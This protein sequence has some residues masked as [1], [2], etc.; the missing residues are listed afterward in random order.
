ME[1]IMQPIK[2]G[3]YKELI[4]SKEPDPPTLPLKF[5]PQ[6]A[7]V[8]THTSNRTEAED[9]VYDFNDGKPSV[10]LVKIKDSSSRTGIFG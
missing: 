5:L 9:W 8:S 2:I 6:Q 7:N 1:A 3:T 10:H 4:P